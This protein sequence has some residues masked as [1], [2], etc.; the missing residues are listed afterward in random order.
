MLIIQDSTGMYGYFLSEVT[1]VVGVC[2]YIIH[3][4]SSI[5]RV[6]G[7]LTNIAGVSARTGHFLHWGQDTVDRLK[8]YCLATVTQPKFTKGHIPARSHTCHAPLKRD[9]S[10]Y[11]GIP[12]AAICELEIKGILQAAT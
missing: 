8:A 4:L 10:R 7:V 2:I 6:D 1:N 11:F 3:L 12:C 5:L 9:L